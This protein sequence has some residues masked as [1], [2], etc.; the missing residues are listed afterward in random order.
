MP[1]D[2][3]CGSCDMQ[4]EELDSKIDC[5]DCRSVYHTGKCAGIS[6]ATIKSKGEQ[7]RSA[8]RCSNCR[9]SK[10]RTPQLDR[11]SNDT[12]DQDVRA[13][14]KSINEKLEYLLP[15][16]ETVD[17]VEDTVQ[18]MS[19]QYDELL[20]RVE[21]NEREVRELKHR[22]DKIEKQDDE[23]TQ[24]KNEMDCL[25]WR[26]RKLNLEFHGIKA[27]KDENLIDEINK[28][29]TLN[30]LP[31]LQESDIVST[32][33]LPSKQDKIPGIICRFAKQSVRDKWWQNRKTLCQGNDSIF[34]LE[35]L[36]KRTR[37]LLTETKLWAKANN[38]KYVWHNNNK[39]LVRKADGQN[40]VVI[41]CSSDRDKLKQQIS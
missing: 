26:S 17:S 7:Y 21:K 15:L 32:H 10:G 9:R 27:M 37:T 19:D 41:S 2:E 24:L 3:H 22:V 4:L 29:A 6:D 12:D 23:I 31:Q 20:T 35:N 39:V 36:T 14:L 30:N 13:L 5:S 38:Y 16:K 11:S 25:E 8:W 18:Y 28:L 40:A 1:L 34:V 33:R